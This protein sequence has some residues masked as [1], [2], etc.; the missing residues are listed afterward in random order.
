MEF[1]ISRPADV[2]SQCPRSEAQ[3][4][5]ALSEDLSNESHAR[6]HCVVPRGPDFRHPRGP[7]VPHH[8]R[9]PLCRGRRPPSSTEGDG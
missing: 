5:V 3:R 6:L 2:A 1:T 4:P 7:A 9:R 8:R